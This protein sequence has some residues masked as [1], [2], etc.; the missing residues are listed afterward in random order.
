MAACVC[1]EKGS[2]YCQSCQGP[3]VVRPKPRY[4]EPSEVN[5]SPIGDNCWCSKQ[6]I[7]PAQ[8]PK[9]CG[10]V[11]EM[12][13]YMNAFSNLLGRRWL[14]NAIEFKTQAAQRLAERLQRLEHIDCY[15]RGVAPGNP[16]RY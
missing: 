10:K 11:R 8:L 9:T 12:F 1:S 13:Q 14:E 3:T 4:Y 5:L 2:D 16:I 6:L 7:E 15:K